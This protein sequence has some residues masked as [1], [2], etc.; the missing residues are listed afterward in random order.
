M[1]RTSDVL[2][3]R[4]CHTTPTIAL[5]DLTYTNLGN[6]VYSFFADHRVLVAT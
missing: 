1:T 4:T 2:P 5:A 6:R 3:V